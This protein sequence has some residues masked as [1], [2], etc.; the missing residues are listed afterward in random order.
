MSRKQFSDLIKESESGTL[1]PPGAGAN[2]SPD[3]ATLYLLKDTV[4]ALSASL[5]GVKALL[6]LQEASGYFL[7]LPMLNYQT[8]D[9]KGWRDIPVARVRTPTVPSLIYVAD[10]HLCSYRNYGHPIGVAVG[11]ADGA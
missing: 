11:L 7:H 4:Q 2:V 10:P 6:H 5:P 8:T 3:L 1:A 9:H